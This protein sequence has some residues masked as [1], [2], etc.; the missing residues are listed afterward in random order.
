MV[1]PLRS[2]DWAT[3]ISRVGNLLAQLPS[4]PIGKLA[5]RLLLSVPTGQYV[6]WLLANGA[7]K[8]EP[9]LGQDPVIGDRV[10]VWLNKKVQDVFVNARGNNEWELR[11]GT[12]YKMGRNG[13]DRVPGV[14]LPHETPL[15][16]GFGQPTP[17]YRKQLSEMGANYSQI[18]AD[19]CGSPV[20]V[21]GDGKEFLRSQRDELVNDANN[22]LDSKSAVL[23]DQDSG[24]VSNPDRILFHPFMIFSPEVAQLNLWLRTISPRLVIV[25]RWSYFRRMDE[26]L[27]ASA[28]MVVLANRRVENN[29]NAIDETDENQELGEDFRSM[30]L[31]QLPNGIFARKF[32]SRVEPPRGIDEELEI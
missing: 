13:V 27:F 2:P 32:V 23:L 21:I 6:S 19:Q 7:L 26:A 25:T 4:T 20:V 14:V 3:S 10:T 28:P 24:Q 22:W 5:P 11:D 17:E 29:W 8:A 9:K 16:R 15:N 12:S 31:N 18:Y 1:L 30:K